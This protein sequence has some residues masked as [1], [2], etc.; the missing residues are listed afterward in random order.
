[1]APEAGV[2]SNDTLTTSPN[3]T[4]LTSGTYHPYGTDAASSSPTQRAGYHDYSRNRFGDRL[5]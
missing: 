2:E 4:A 3:N 1:V 5:K